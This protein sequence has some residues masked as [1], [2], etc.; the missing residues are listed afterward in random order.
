MSAPCFLAHSQ[1]FRLSE[2]DET[3]I[4][5]VLQQ[6]QDEVGDSVAIG[7]YP[8]SFVQQSHHHNR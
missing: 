2:Y 5:A 6:V 8:V 1:V 7:S 3:R 4:A